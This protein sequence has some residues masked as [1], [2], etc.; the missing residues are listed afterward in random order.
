MIIH[1][2]ANH[3]F[4]FVLGS[5]PTASYPTQSQASA[6]A[7]YTAQNRALQGNSDVQVDDLL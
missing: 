5:Y 6:S 2:I 7:A 4:S 3:L 1:C